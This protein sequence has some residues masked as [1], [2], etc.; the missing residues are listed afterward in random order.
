MDISFSSGFL[1][2]ISVNNV[3]FP[4]FDIFILRNVSILHAK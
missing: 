1:S 3:Y 2:E 4:D